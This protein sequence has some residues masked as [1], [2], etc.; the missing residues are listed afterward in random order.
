VKRSDLV[1]Q[2]RKAIIGISLVD[3]F[4]DSCE[5]HTGTDLE[6]ERFKAKIRE[7]WSRMLV[8]TYKLNYDSED[9]DSMSEEEYIEHNA[10]RFAD[11][12]EQ[13]TELD[14][15]MDMLDG[16]LDPKEELE[17]VKSEGKAKIEATVYE[18]KSKTTKTPSDSRSGVKGGSYEGTPSGKISKKKDARVIRSFSPIAESFKDE[19]KSLID[20]RRIGR[21]KQLFRL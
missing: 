7:I 4:K 21:R 2:T 8:E 19:L 5:E 17:D 14:S 9:E 16:L 13:E 18:V 12:P 15:L 10:L 1:K 11:E 20:R 6:L 3:I